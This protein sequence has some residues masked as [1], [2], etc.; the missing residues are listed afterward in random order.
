MNNLKRF[1]TQHYENAIALKERFKSLEKKDW[2]SI[3]VMMELYVQIG[4]LYNVMNDNKDLI[5]QGRQIDNLGDEI[6]DVLLQLSYLAHLEG[7][8]FEDANK[9]DSYPYSEVDGLSVL[10]GQ[11][12]EAILEKYE[13]RFDKPREGFASRDDFIKDR[14]KKMMTIALNLGNKANI[15]LGLEFGLMCA[16]ATNFVAVRTI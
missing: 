14:I 8:T 12:A 4:H 11:L 15:D 13:Y 3:T 7:V 1:I 9:Y 2:D 5:E 16:D 6:S 10:G